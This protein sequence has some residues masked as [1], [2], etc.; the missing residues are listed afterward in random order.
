MLFAT[1][2]LVLLAARPAAAEPLYRWQFSEWR[3]VEHLGG[4]AAVLVPEPLHEQWGDFVRQ[5]WDFLAGTF[6]QTPASMTAIGHSDGN[7]F[8][9]KA[10]APL[11]GGVAGNTIGGEALI[12]VEKEYVRVEDGPF[13]RFTYSTAHLEV[14]DFG[15]GRPP[16]FGPSA[17]IEMDV[18][19]RDFNERQRWG[20]SQVALARAD[21]G[22]DLEDVFDDIWV[23]DLSGEIRGDNGVVLATG[24][25]WQWDCDTCGDPAYGFHRP[26]LDGPYTERIVLDGVPMHTGFTVR[27]DLVAAA[28][29]RGQGETAASAYAKDPLSEDD[30]GPTEGVTI[31]HAGIVEVEIPRCPFPGLE[32]VAC[33]LDAGM[34][35]ARCL[36]DELPT[37]VTR[38]A[39]RAR[40]LVDQALAA[41]TETKRRSLGKRIVNAL[42]SADR[43]LARRQNAKRGPKPSV[44]CGADTHGVLQRAM[45]RAGAVVCAPSAGLL[46]FAAASYEVSED[47]GSV[48]V[49]IT[50]TGGSDGKVTAT[51]T[52]GAST[53]TVGLDWQ[54]PAPIVVFNRRESGSRSLTVPILDDR[55]GEPDE[56][57][58]L[59]LT[60]EH[61]CATGAQ[62]TTVVTIVDDDWVEPPP[63]YTVG[64]TVSG[65]EGTGLEIEEA[66]TGASVEI[67]SDGPFTLP[68]DFLEGA[69]YQVRVATQPTSPL[70]VCSVTNGSGTVGTANVVDVVVTCDTPA[71]SGALDPSF[72]SGG[73]VTATWS[74]AARAIAAQA[75]GK[76][77]VLG[78]RHLARYHADGTLDAS[79]G[80]GGVVG[81]AFGT[82][83]DVEAYDVVVTTD[84]RILV[85]GY[86][87]QTF[88]GRSDFAL[89]RY[90]ADGTLDATFGSAGV[91]VTDF[92]GS[93]DRAYRI[94]LQP[95]GKIVLA[96]HAAVVLG[97]NDFAVA[98]YDANGALDASFGSGG[99]ATVDIAGATDLAS[100]AALQADG[101]IVLVGR[102]AA[103]GGAN[104]DVGVV[105]F[106]ADG[107]LDP[108]FGGDGVVR[109]DL[110]GGTW[111]EAVGV[112]VASDGGILVAVQ[113]ILGASYDFL[114][115]RFRPDGALDTSFGTLGVSSHDFN[116]G[117][118]FVRTLA[119]LPDGRVVLAGQAESATVND[120]ALAVFQPSG[121]L[122]A[123]FGAGGALTLDLLGA[124]DSAQSVA[125]QADGR[126]VVGGSTRNGTSNEVAL[127]RLT[128]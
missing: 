21:L 46:S 48:T 31:E 55:A 122:D 8:W 117:D 109:I 120:M 104:P 97:E 7:V 32:G 91:A 12:S 79:F 92:F 126:L 24:P 51:I 1:C 78:P 121:V 69:S 2:G 62:A 23:L 116:G 95:D 52:P 72:G 80:A 110:S 36:A 77:L 10:I 30:L 111:D 65:L 76:L 11:R 20:M 28:L 105:R 44:L 84:G 27:F 5:E 26:K 54:R 18:T 49:E 85:A 53:A 15:S 38:P 125:L 87:S 6:F 103:S 50:R 4:L 60:T 71:P 118:D 90:L 100:A 14:V 66:I 57:V 17:R 114:L 119:L 9:A 13:L 25:R 93:T 89:A 67:A 86:V 70:Q 16:W 102:V 59:E 124:S 96:G 45:A 108:S 113:T 81:V 39:A 37:N 106:L 123:S 82:G 33:L 29:D 98:R 64:G 47:A 61:G 42:R 73:L 83:I 68:Y 94:L 74:S 112:A 34:P 35:P 75:D 43:A 3:E 41:T 56:T 115:A 99:L 40:A 88:S 128:P 22:V 19:V 127:V 58:V 101:A 107:T 63:T